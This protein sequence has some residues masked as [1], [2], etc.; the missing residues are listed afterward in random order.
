[1]LKCFKYAKYFLGSLKRTILVRF[2]FEAS[3]CHSKIILIVRNNSLDGSSSPGNNLLR[4]F[5]YER[6]SFQQRQVLPSTVLKVMKWRLGKCRSGLKS[7]REFQ[8][9]FDPSFL[10]SP[11]TKENISIF[12]SQKKQSFSARSFWQLVIWSTAKNDT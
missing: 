8:K 7:R 11:P 5:H 12:F 6:A 2:I 4:F 9:G 10:P 1:M 3:V